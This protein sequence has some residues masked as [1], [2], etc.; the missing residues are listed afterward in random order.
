MKNS[1]MSSKKGA[2]AS[3][4]GKNSS[5][6]REDSSESSSSE[7]EDYDYATMNY[8]GG[9]Y[10]RQK[11]KYK[12]IIKDDRAVVPILNPYEIGSY[13]KWSRILE[14]VISQDFGNNLASIITAK[15]YVDPIPKP[16]ERQKVRRRICLPIMVDAIAVAVKNIL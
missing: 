5:R 1:K 3:N 15:D 9:G 11:G 13:D 8:G 10:H 4:N 16:D 7:Y 2:T 12:D 14:N 6:K